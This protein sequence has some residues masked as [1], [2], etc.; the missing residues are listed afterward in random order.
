MIFA[1]L[2]VCMP[3][4]PKF[5]DAGPAAVGYWAAALAYVRGHDLDGMLPDTALGV[6]L[7]VGTAEGRELSDRLVSVGLFQRV[8]GGYLIFNYASK[9]ET[10]AQVETRRAA[11]RER[12]AKS[13]GKATANG[14]AHDAVT[15]ENV[16]P[17]VTRASNANVTPPVTASAIAVVPVRARSDSDSDSDSVLIFSGSGRSRSPAAQPSQ[18]CDGESGSHVRGAA[19]FEISESESETLRIDPDRLVA[20]M[21]TIERDAFER[22]PDL[23]TAADLQRIANR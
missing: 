20:N 22:A 19:S 17:D 13:R 21:T 15:D 7:A 10:K 3:T 9:N 1:K 2:D 23:F 14:S 16:T 8:R 11:T 12:V 18:D 5:I 6:L 4:H